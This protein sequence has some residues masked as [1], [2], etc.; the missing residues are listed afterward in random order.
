MDTRAGHPDRTLTEPRPPSMQS[1][2]PFTSTPMAPRTAI[3]A[4]SLRH[5]RHR[6]RDARL[7]LLDRARRRVVRRTERDGDP[8]AEPDRVGVTDAHRHHRG[9][10]HGPCQQRRTRLHRQEA[11]AEAAG[12]LGK[13]QLGPA[14]RQRRRIGRPTIAAVLAPHHGD[15]GHQRSQQKVA[16]Q[17]CG[18]HE[19]GRPGQR[20]GAKPAV[21]QPGA[22]PGDEQHR[23][24]EGHA[25][26]A[27]HP[28]RPG[29]QPC[30]QE[31]QRPVEP[32]PV[33]QAARHGGR[34][35][36]RSHACSHHPTSL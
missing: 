20:V 29:E 25:F 14:R 7:H 9:A 11:R 4:G 33:H 31:R 34:A 17:P 6:R 3:T 2:W 21:H 15:A 35:R 32:E 28:H 8:G 36:Q 10:R 1:T 13:A 27:N 23:P 26:A 24:M 19:H 22:M 16:A 5:G 12:A 30:H 18:D